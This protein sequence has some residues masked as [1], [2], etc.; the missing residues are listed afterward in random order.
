MQSLIT[1][2]MS[3][4][5][6]KHNK[7]DANISQH[8]NSFTSLRTQYVKTCFNASKT[9]RHTT[10]SENKTRSKAFL[11]V[12]HV[13]QGDQKA[14]VTASFGWTASK[15]VYYKHIYNLERGLTR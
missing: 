6:L 7:L 4:G 9:L 5:K 2:P 12:K 10:T 13:L 1:A 14:R 11:K 15:R 8:I 3:I